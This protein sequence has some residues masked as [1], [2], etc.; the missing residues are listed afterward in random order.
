MANAGLRAAWRAPECGARTRSGG[1]CRHKAVRGRRRCR[2]HGGLST[3][4][5]AARTPSSTASTPGRRSS[6]GGSHVTYCDRPRPSFQPWTSG[7]RGAATARRG[8]TPRTPWFLASLA[9]VARLSPAPGPTSGSSRTRLS[10]A[11]LGDDKS[12]SRDR[13]NKKVDCNCRGIG[14]EAMGTTSNAIAKVLPSSPSEWRP[15][16][17]FLTRTCPILPD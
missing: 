9:L 7:R 16:G 5:W 13:P 1:R 3:G 2:F 6:A 8:A 4:R 17:L 15:S 14:A 10:S 11:G 12:I